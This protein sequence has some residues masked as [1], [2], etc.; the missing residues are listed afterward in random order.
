[1]KTYFSLI[2]L[3]FAFVV[4]CEKCPAPYSL[5]NPG[6]E[7]MVNV[8]IVPHTH[9]DVGWLKTVDQYYYGSNTKNQ[10]A[11]VQYILDSVIGELA[12][13]PSRRFVYVELAFFW[14]WWNEQNDVTRNLVRMFV[15]EGRLEFVIGAWC[16][17]DEATTYYNDII[18]QQTLGLQFILKEFGEC[19]RPKVAWQL[20]PFGHS[21]E[22]ASLFAQFGF[23]GLFL[24]RL[25][26][27]D[28]K[29]RADTKTRE[30]VWMASDNLGENG[31]IFT[32]ILP[33]IYGPP[34]GFCFDEK[35]DDDPIMDNPAYEDYN[36]DDK[37]KSFVNW[38]NSK[39]N[40]YKT[41]N[42]IATMGSDFQYANAHMWFKNLDKLIYY[43]NQQRNQTKVNVFYSTPSCYLNSL[44]KANISWPTK[45]DDFFPYAHKP[46]A[47]W[48]G[49]FTSRTTLKGYVRR[50]NNYL[51]AIR[52]LTAISSL[53]SDSVQQALFSLDD[54]IGIAQHHD[55][56]SGTERQ[57]VAKDYAKR[58]AIGTEKTRSIINE[59]YAKILNNQ[60]LS[61]QYLCPLL[62]ISECLPIQNK[63]NFTVIIY[64]PLARESESWIRIP[65]SGPSFIVKDAYT[66]QTIQSEVS[67][68]YE[69]TKKIPERSDTS[70][71]EILFRTV[72]DP[73]GFKVF[74]I[75]KSS[76]KEK[77]EKFSNQVK[78]SFVLKNQNLQLSFD[79]D[80]EL[81]QIQ[82]FDSENINTNLKQTF[83][84]YNS[85]VG[86]NSLPDLQS[87]GA[88]I[89]RP[90]TQE[91]TCL[92]VTKY[93]LKQSPLVQEVHQIFDNWVSQTIRLYDN[94]QSVE[95]EWQ[96]GPI[97]I[98]LLVGK[99]VISLFASDLVSNGTF[100]TDANGR[101]ILKRV[102]NYRPSWPNFN[103]TEPVSG[104]YYPINSRIFIRDEYAD[105]TSRQ[106][107]LVT[108]RSQGGSSI[109]DGNI[110]VMVHRR[111]L[112]DDSLGVTEP[113]NELGLTLHGLISKGK[114]YLFF[115]SSQSSAM[116][117][118]D[119]AHKVNMQPLITF[120]NETSTDLFK[121][122]NQFKVVQQSLPENVELLT[123]AYD[124]STNVPGVNALIVRFEHFYEYNE[125]FILS[126][127]ASFDM[128]ELF[129]S[130]FNI[131]NFE[132]LTLG[133]NMN[134]DELQNRLKWTYNSQQAT[135]ITHLV[136]KN[137]SFIINLQPMQIRTFRVWY[138]PLV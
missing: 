28:D 57:H 65:V 119:K 94:A 37:V 116:L 23:D 36:V 128:K 3:I 127:D 11:A 71:Y 96:I 100:Y 90:S 74:N 69:E 63:N 17:N 68:I 131:L 27:Q 44:H 48:T 104:N 136:D 21:R 15:S 106:L 55:A 53:N 39:R 78:S 79:A 126:Q 7:G 98:D 114:H 113:L 10:N 8:H 118:R 72:L 88:Y 41:D 115:N 35:C 24:G 87:S 75:S 22:Q 31:T 62:N 64:N 89:F 121:N 46:H 54:A 93:S 77:K 135:S 25:D 66:G 2:L 103:Q 117:H 110:E 16:M 43:V 61:T 38:A 47:F 60:K 9:D 73:L 42:I 83:C 26:Y 20:D 122:L 14:R 52:Q 84:Y 5:C 99:E 6:I 137:I 125:D 67:E 124:F 95:F 30:F 34:G 1:M 130:T 33:N 102:R 80:G 132:E 50:T 86:I 76:S 108:D 82:L 134:V 111:L 49:Y 112:M 92:K 59:A 85:F 107:T 13:N 109:N 105:V 45:E 29:H 123:L 81:Q 58:L 12:K 97:P 56:V 18:D 101:E 70:D 138:L 120:V 129:N 4:K 19:A 91:P 51:Q 32:G 40:V 133:A